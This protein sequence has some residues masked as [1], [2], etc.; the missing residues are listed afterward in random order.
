MLCIVYF[1][2]W[3][4]GLFSLVYLKLIFKRVKMKK[5]IGSLILGGAIVSMVHAQDKIQIKSSVNSTTL[6][7]I[8]I[9][10]TTFVP[11]S[12]VFNLSGGSRIAYPMADQKWTFPQI[13]STSSQK[14]NGLNGLGINYSI[15]D[16]Q[17]I[18][19]SELVSSFSIMNLSGQVL[20]QS[21]SM[22]KEWNVNLKNTGVLILNVQNA[23]QNKRYLLR[24]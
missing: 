2:I 21:H 13:T 15:Q 11:D 3:N 10:K 20:E 19:K 9:L 22:Q 8:Q 16:H 7:L 1:I 24:Q 18:V 6:S 5:I 23:D 14:E 12:V 4:F 17:L